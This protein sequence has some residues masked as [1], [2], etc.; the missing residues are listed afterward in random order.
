MWANHDMPM[1]TLNPHLFERGNSSVWSA[2]VDW[3]NWT[4]MVERFIWQYFK[5]PNY[6]KLDGKPVFAIYFLDKLLETFGDEDGIR[7]ALNYFDEE[8]KKAGFPG[9]HFQLSGGVWTTEKH[10]HRIEAMG[11]HSIVPLTMGGIDRDYIKYCTNSI[12]IRERLS[13]ALNIPFFPC[14]SIAYDDTPRFMDHQE[15]QVHFHRSP[16]AFAMLLAKTKEWV[17]NHPDQPKLMLINAWNEWAE[18]CY[19]LPDMNYGFGYLEAV[20]DVMNGR[21]EQYK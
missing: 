9:V 4:V 17:D 13:Q 3:N 6:F 19:L 16:Q 14:I 18:D 21:Y 11:F 5:K 2:D 8:A 20:K 12:A 15:D 10:L 1:N 7:K